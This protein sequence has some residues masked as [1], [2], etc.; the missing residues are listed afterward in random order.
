[1]EKKTIVLG[2]IGSDCHAVG[3]KI[4]D[5]SFTNAGFNVVNIGVLSSQEDFINAAIET[6]ADLICVSSLY[7]QGEIDCKGLREKCDEAGLKGIK[8]FVGGN[9]VVGKQ[10]WPDVEQ[11]FKAMGF[12]RVYPPG[13]SPETTIADMKEVL[14]VE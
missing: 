4:L 10:N 2:V 3:N 11:R 6:K 7:G 13:T 14:G 5:H 1:M 12:D 8:L 9:I